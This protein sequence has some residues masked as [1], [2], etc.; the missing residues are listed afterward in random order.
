MRID[1]SRPADTVVIGAGAAGLMAAIWAARG[2]TSRRIVVLDS[3]RRLGAKILISGGGRC[4]VT[5]REIDARSFAG[6][7]RNAIGKVLRS[8]DVERTVDFFREIGVDLECESTGKLFPVSNTA[9]TVLE[10]LLGAARD[11]G[12]EFAHPCRVDRVDPD[13]EGFLVAGSWGSLR[14]P[15]VVLATGGRSIPKSGSDGHGYELA[16]GLGHHVNRTFPALVPL[17]LPAGHWIRSLSGVALEAE[18][19]VVSS[20]GKRRDA[21]RGPVLFT[22]FGLSGPAILDIS[23]F[24]IQARLDDRGASLSA[25]W[26]PGRTAES[27]LDEWERVDTE[28]IGRLLRHRLP[29]RFVEALAAEAA[30]DLAVPVRSLRKDARRRLARDL[31]EHGL[32]VTGDRGY[33]HAEVTAGGVPLSEIRL[34]SMESRIRTG[35]HLCGEICDVDGRIGGFNFQWAWS[36]GYLAGVGAR[37]ER[38]DRSGS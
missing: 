14:A 27:L 31:V 29:N 21:A 37:G 34:T 13:P 20:S 32:P 38:S 15:R 23:R 35:L 18:L 24:L 17:T 11:L 28:P 36:S 3:A 16:R 2:S 22:H 8:F 9:R 4:N 33:D 19:R 6:S 26:M 7:S 25:N 10:A 1:A 30:I 5:H 12:V